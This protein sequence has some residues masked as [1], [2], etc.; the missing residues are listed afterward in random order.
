MRASR[1]AHPLT[2]PAHRARTLLSLPRGILLLSLVVLAGCASPSSQDDPARAGRDDDGID[3]NGQRVPSSRTLYSMSRVLASQQKD[4]ECEVVLSRLIA[5]HPSFRPSYIDLAEL[6]LRHAR[7]DSAVEV[8]K[9]GI[10]VAPEDA[11]MHND[12][13]MCLL[14]QGE[15][16]QALEAFTAAAAGVPRD[17]RARAN[18]AVALGMLG[19]FDEAL[20]VYEQVVPAAEAHFNL[21]VLC[22]ARKDTERAAR[23]FEIAENLRSGKPQATAPAPAP[24]NHP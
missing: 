8:L 24:S 5:D 17:V 23:E 6:Y 4:A 7:V 12:L 10:Q 15:Y 1:P 16:E 18:L 22:Q 2:S 13:G 20:S 19:R 9:A 14:M 3:R 11:V 21:G